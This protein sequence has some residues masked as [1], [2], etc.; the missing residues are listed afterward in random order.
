M[1]LFAASA[2]GKQVSIGEVCDKAADCGN[3]ADCYHGVCAAMCA[4][5]SECKGELVCARHRCL[6][7]TGEPKR[8]GPANRPAEER[9]DPAAYEV[10]KVRPGFRKDTPEGRHDGDVT[11]ELRAIHGELEQIRAEQQRLREAVEKLQLPTGP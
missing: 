4:D 11:A 2:C 1:L 7:A 5:D 10:A 6:L 8:K 9:A 3:G